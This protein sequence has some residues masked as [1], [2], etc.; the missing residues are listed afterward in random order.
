[1]DQGKHNSKH[2]VVKAGAKRKW[3]NP[4]LESSQSE[5]LD[6]GPSDND[7]VK[8]RPIFICSVLFL[9]SF[10]ISSV[11]FMA[12][13][14]KT[15][16]YLGEDQPIFTRFITRGTEPAYGKSPFRPISPSGQLI[17]RKALEQWTGDDDQNRMIKFKWIDNGLSFQ[18]GDA[19][20]AIRIRNV[21]LGPDN[22]KIA[23]TTTDDRAYFY[24]SSQDKWLELSGPEL[25]FVPKRVGADILR[26]NSAETEPNS[27]SIPFSK[28]SGDGEKVFLPSL[29]SSFSVI[30]DIESKTVGR[31][32][33]P[34]VVDIGTAAFPSDNQR[35]AIADDDAGI[36][37]F[38]L[39]SGQT[40]QNRGKSSLNTGQFQYPSYP[41]FGIEK[42][43]FAAND[44]R[45]FVFH[46]SGDISVLD[47][48]NGIE[49]ASE[50]TRIEA[51]K[52]FF[53][54]DISPDGNI[55][56]AASALG[57][58]IWDVNKRNTPIQRFPTEGTVTS[59]DISRNLQKPLLA[60]STEYGSIEVIDLTN[61]S[62]FDPEFPSKP[63]KKELNRQGQPDSRITEIKFSP[64][65]STLHAIFEGRGIWQYFLDGETP[66]RRISPENVFELSPTGR[67]FVKQEAGGG[68]GVYELVNQSFPR[69]I[70]LDLDAGFTDTFMYDLSGTNSNLFNIANFDE[71]P[72]A[73][74]RTKGEGNSGDIY[75]I[76]GDNQTIFRS[77]DAGE[78]W[79]PANVNGNRVPDRPPS[80]LLAV[81]FDQNIGVAV[82]DEGTVLMSQDFGET[83]NQRDIAGEFPPKLTDV[84][85]VRQDDA[86]QAIAVG[87]DNSGSSK[88]H[89]I[90]I[91]DKPTEEA[92]EW[93]K[94]PQ[95][96]GHPALFFVFLG[97]MITSGVGGIYYYLVW[98]RGN[99]NPQVIS[100]GKSDRAIGWD[101]HDVLGLKEL[102]MQTSRFLRN[103][104]T[105]APLVIGVS[106][107]WGSG[108]S[109]LMNL[110]CKDLQRRGSY[111]VEFNAWHHQNEDHLLAALFENIRAQGIPRFW[112]VRGFWF[113]LC[114]IGPRII[115]QLR[116]L[117]PLC[118]MIAFLVLLADI[119]FKDPLWDLVKE[120]LASDTA[121]PTESGNSV[122]SETASQSDK[123]KKEEGDN[124]I[125]NLI[126][127]FI[128]AAG[129]LI[130]MRQ[131][132][133]AF[134]QMPKSMIRNFSAIP[135]I[136]NLNNRLSFRY[137]FSRA[138]SEVCNAIKLS[139]T[140]DLIIFVDDLDRCDP[141]SVLT[142]LEAVNYLV[143]AGDCIV[144]LGFDPLQVEH[145][146]ASAMKDIADGIPED[147]IPE[148][149]Y[150]DGK[151]YSESKRQA[152][153]R[154]YMEKLINLEIDI[155]TLGA[156]EAAAM[157]RHPSPDNFGL[158]DKRDL[159]W[160]QN[161]N[162]IKTVL[163]RILT[164]FM[165]AAGA[166][167][168]F[169]ALHKDFSY[170][171]SQ[172]QSA[173]NVVSEE[174]A[175]N[176]NE[177]TEITEEQ[178]DAENRENLPS[179]ENSQ[180]A[181][182]EKTNTVVFETDPDAQ[183]LIKQ[184]SALPGRISSYG[185]LLAFILWA[186]LAFYRQYYKTVK[187]IEHDP[188]EFVMALADANRLVGKV[189]NTPRA[190][191]RFMNGVRYLSVR[192]RR[193]NYETGLLDRIVSKVNL[194]S[195]DF[196]Q[197]ASSEPE[198]KDKAVIA[199]ALLQT[200]LGKSNNILGENN[201]TGH[202]TQ[203]SKSNEISPKRRELMK[204][205]RTYVSASGL[206]EMDQDVTQK[207]F[208]GR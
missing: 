4:Q 198:V 47:I 10:L 186:F 12:G 31:S 58:E 183:Q 18:N 101:D 110:I 119:L 197:T 21:F 69:L 165:M 199:L 114:L 162:L 5:A 109:S 20:S 92:S 78:N 190:V 17:D 39:N 61:M 86:L 106:G 43:A 133:T 137:N 52:P 55:I 201:L 178:T 182:I 48:S 89:T 154:H 53:H 100:A 146:V 143:S 169:E 83:W 126:A 2:K 127:G 35:I 140:T 68:L 6:T 171:F 81:S 158:E 149:F 23:V 105:E 41:A 116:F 117:L 42:L 30:F 77:V 132:W 141:N 138:F 188:D 75:I 62:N 205:L 9:I 44:R 72:N 45:L 208:R 153:A 57:I 113:R 170:L 177:S 195:P 26:R 98:M 112:T 14:P 181:Y 125:Q 136:G 142:V 145:A 76:V 103:D 16:P 51:A 135:T 73:I 96:R 139:G 70:S 157:I 134:P 129:F 38:D 46:K 33:I 121:P 56:A 189:N 151:I 99:R 150:E 63:D 187:N 196:T 124:M 152:F 159:F 203:L 192:T 84:K 175:N 37:I 173:Q 120:K 180:R 60:Y 156:D 91:N 155:P 67:A 22:Q 202:L 27:L 107:G 118:V 59:L 164:L 40:N 108:K 207:L 97:L 168:V 66:P 3:V 94:I 80:N 160:L 172:D 95:V 191:R 19:A 65:G 49:K 206:E 179:I 123:E 1:M 93:Q 204:E 82:G 163:D 28:F 11:N 87:V 25:K 122:A 13:D 8:T 148:E 161:R 85:L 102:A 64:D 32:V 185:L 15:D 176:E 115:R 184:S 193:V 29:N 130:W 24:S 167:L 54:A 90:Y 174:T 111:A 71:P 7:D 166:F 200:Y 34:S 104:Q 88:F 144:I 147:Q 131:L 194:V 36:F 128:P 50:L 79:S 74:A